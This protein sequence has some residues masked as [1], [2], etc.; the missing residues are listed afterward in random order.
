MQ[1]VKVAAQRGNNLKINKFLFQAAPWSSR[2]P[3]T[4]V[5]QNWAP[6][7]SVYETIV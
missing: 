5:L 4:I 2:M 3:G 7:E 1:D 6:W